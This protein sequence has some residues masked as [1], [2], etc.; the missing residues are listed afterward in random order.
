[1]QRQGIENVIPVEI[2]TLGLELKMQ[3]QGRKCNIKM[4]NVIMI[5]KHEKRSFQ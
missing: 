1:M 4:E 3:H 2:T 5:K